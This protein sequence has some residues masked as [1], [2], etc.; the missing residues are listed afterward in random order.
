MTRRRRAP[1]AT[2]ASMNTLRNWL[3]LEQARGVPS[4]LLGTRHDPV[5][6]VAVSEAKE[7]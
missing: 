5:E 1:T 3:E 4:P 6:M 7:E 2:D